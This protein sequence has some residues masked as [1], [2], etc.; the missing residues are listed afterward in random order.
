MT[1]IVFYTESPTLF[2]ACKKGRHTAG[3]GN[4]GVRACII[5]T[6]TLRPVEAKFACRLSPREV[7]AF[8]RGSCIVW[9]PPLKKAL[10]SCLIVLAIKG[11]KL[12]PVKT[13]IPFVKSTLNA[14]FA[15]HPSRGHVWF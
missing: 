5:K 3:T 6:R 2:S 15:V 8:P 9:R 7:V 10:F 13:I 4:S 12:W 1:N 14:I 11:E